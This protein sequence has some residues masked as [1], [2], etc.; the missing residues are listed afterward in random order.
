MLTRWLVLTFCAMVMGGCVVFGWAGGATM[1]DGQV[2]ARG[3]GGEAG[4][5]A[6]GPLARGA[7]Y[8]G[9]PVRVR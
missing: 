8:S 2:T 6:R 1:R 5:D 9:E 3:V 4:V 7:V